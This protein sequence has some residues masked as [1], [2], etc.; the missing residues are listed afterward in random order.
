MPV[1]AFNNAH[2][3]L[4]AVFLCKTVFQHLTISDNYN[5]YIQLGRNKGRKSNLLVEKQTGE[6]KLGGCA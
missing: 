6:F 3:L 4:N 5:N 1:I 2:A